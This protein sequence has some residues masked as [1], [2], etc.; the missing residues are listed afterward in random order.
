MFSRATFG[1][2]DQA[3][4]MPSTDACNWLG[5]YGLPRKCE[6]VTNM[7]FSLALAEFPV[8]YSTRMPGRMAIAACA[9]EEPALLGKGSHR[10]A[11][12]VA[13]LGS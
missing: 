4:S 1:K 9:S 10:A 5:V 11:C 2:P 3:A 13:E 12:F 8:V 7:A 6:P